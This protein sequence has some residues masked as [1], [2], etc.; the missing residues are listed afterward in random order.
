MRFL[1]NVVVEKT[2]T[3]DKP[4]D[5]SGGSVQL[6]TKDLPEQLTMSFSSSV[7]H[8]SNVTGKDGFL[9][10]P[11]SNLE[12]LGFDNSFRDLPDELNDPSGV[13]QNTPIDGSLEDGLAADVVHKSFNTTFSQKPRQA[14]PGQSYSFSFGN[15][16]SVN[17]RPLGVLAGLTY[18]RSY[19]FYSDGTVARYDLTQPDAPN[20]DPQYIV[21][22]VKATEKVQ[23]GGLGKISYSIHENH[24]LSTRFVYNR[25]GEQENRY[26]IGYQ[27]GSTMGYF[28]TRT[29][30]YI[31]QYV[32]SFQLEGEHFF[33]PLKMDW[34]FSYSKSNRNEPDLR[35][36]TNDW[37]LNTVTDSVTGDTLSI[38]TVYSLESTGTGYFPVHV[39]REIDVRNR[40]FQLNFSLPLTKRY[41]KPVKLS[42]GASYLDK[43]RVNLERRFKINY[44]D[45]NFDG[46]PDHFV[47]NEDMGID[48]ENSVLNEIA[49]IDD[50]LEF[51]SA[52][53]VKTEDTLFDNQGNI[54][55]IFPLPEPFFD[56]IVTVDTLRWDTIS[57][58]TTYT[59]VYKKNIEESL[60]TAAQNNFKGNRDVLGAYLMMQLPI[61]R[62]LR[63]IG[64]TRYETTDMEIRS[65]IN[66]G[67]QGSIDAGDWLPSASFTYALTDRMN[68]RLAYG[69]TLARPTFKE[70]SKLITYE[71]MKGLIFNGN[72]D[73]TYTTINNLDFRWEW[74]NGP[75]RI[76]AASAFYKRFKHPIERAY[77]GPNNDITYVNV[78]RANV[79]GLELEIRQSLELISRWFSNFKFESN[80]TYSH[81]RIDIPEHEMGT[82]IFWD[83]SA[84]D[85]RQLQGQSP[86]ILNLGL[87]Y[88]NY[89]TKTVASL[90]FNIFGKRLSLVGRGGIPDVF[91]QPRPMLDMTLSQRIWGAVSLKLSAKNLLNEKVSEIITYKDIDYTFREYSIG[92]SISFGLSYK[93]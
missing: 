38:D 5:F 56:T 59:F 34:R 20:L 76:I 29:L 41:S 51:D 39:F 46:N 64:G 25:E 8:N 24:K 15:T 16:Y 85:T 88:E 80:F 23:W 77:W 4:G 21:P 3:P 37:Y 49:D 58:D 89:E 82:R 50:S 10:S 55:F 53:I 40:E 32:G 79:F 31:E 60:I 72:P 61:L 45:P 93:I 19:S 78:D 54:I 52:F 57:V 48:W 1:D 91:E 43:E 74:F 84:S 47:N 6:Q 87:T 22:D 36:F 17:E 83:S 9:S 69:R 11:R 33:K 12:W 68:L 14:P 81:S 90:M 30:Q 2:F 66:D 26:I 71:F 27:S 35:Y 7:S 42:F 65:S 67:L 44:T 62:N 86:Y 92:R 63:F 75:G 18:K 70:K 13:K 28:Q 73:L